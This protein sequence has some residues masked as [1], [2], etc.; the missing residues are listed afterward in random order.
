MPCQIRSTANRNALIEFGNFFMAA[1]VNFATSNVC[2]MFL[3]KNDAQCKDRSLVLFD[4]V[5][6]IGIVLCEFEC[7]LKNFFKAF[8]CVRDIFCFRRF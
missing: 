5:G 4:R 8:V 3:S 1:T 2:D 7:S 6:A